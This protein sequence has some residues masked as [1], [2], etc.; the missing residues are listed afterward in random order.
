MSGHCYHKYHDA[1][2]I[3]FI[4]YFVL[5]FSPSSEIRSDWITSILLLLNTMNELN[6]GRAD[7]ACVDQI[8]QALQESCLLT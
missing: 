5:N 2:L 1:I 6:F 3:E 4:N 8:Q 7:L